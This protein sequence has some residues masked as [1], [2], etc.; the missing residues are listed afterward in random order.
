MV[1]L[2]TQREQFWA[3]FFR[4]PDG[5]YNIGGFVDAPFRGRT[6]TEATKRLLSKQRKGTCCGEANHFYNKTHSE[7][8]KLIISLSKKGKKH[9]DIQKEN[10]SKWTSCEGNPAVKLD[11]DSVLEIKKLYSTGNFTYKEISE[12]YKVSKSCIAFIIQGR[13]WTFG[14]KN[15]P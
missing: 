3:D 13:S 15:E 12:I 6:H 7:E 14:V 1:D 8:V 4:F 11:I 10:R 5:I 2:L 9:T